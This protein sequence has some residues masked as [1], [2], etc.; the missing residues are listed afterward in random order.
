M[1][2]HSPHAPLTRPASEHHLAEVVSV[3]DVETTGR[4]DVRVY[5]YDGI[6]GQDSR[7]AARVCVPFAG[8][9]RG[10]FFIPDV[11]DEV[12]VAFINGDARQAVVLGALWNGKNQPAESLGSDRIDRW[13]IVGKRGTRIAIVEEGEGALIRLSTPDASGSD[14]AFCEISRENNGYI[15]LSA[16]GSKVRIDQDGVS[17]QTSGEVSMEASSTSITSATVDVDAGQSTFNGKVDA[18][19]VQTPAVMGSTYTPGGGN[20]W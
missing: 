6:D 11:G 1:I 10:A 16:G 18:L 14:V 15:E 8:D 13:T 7:I 20:V 12:L 17:I 19:A 5:S 3:S 4:I 9:G 2:G